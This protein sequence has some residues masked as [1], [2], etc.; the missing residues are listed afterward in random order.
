MDDM[1]ADYQARPEMDRYE[2]EGI[3]D[4]YDLNELSAQ[5]RMLVD[6]DLFRRE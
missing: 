5:G 3:D 6:E 4:D 1:E 2:S